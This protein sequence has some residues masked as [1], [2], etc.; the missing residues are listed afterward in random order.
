MEQLADSL[1]PVVLSLEADHSA[2]RWK[3]IKPNGVGVG[4]I[5]RTVRS[6][7]PSAESDVSELEP[8][9]FSEPFFRIVASYKQS[10]LFV[11]PISYV[12]DLQRGSNPFDPLVALTQAMNGLQ[13]GERIRIS[14]GILGVAQGAHKRGEA[15]ITQSTIHPLQW[16]TGAGF[17]MRF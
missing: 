1:A 9:Q 16:A 6:I 10:N 12:T 7:Y 3:I 15:L 8:E 11:A 2:I 5:E 4:L 13:A 14:L 17:R